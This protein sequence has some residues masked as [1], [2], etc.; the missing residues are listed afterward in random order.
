[1]KIPMIQAIE[2]MN[3][4][5]KFT[6]VITNSPDDRKIKG[7]ANRKLCL[8]LIKAGELCLKV[9]MKIVDVS[10]TT[11]MIILKEFNEAGLIEFFS[12]TG[13]KSK[14]VNVL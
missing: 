11:I 9:L 7:A 10:R 1:M 5:P 12:T 6:E 4:T 14:I 2:A 8:E 13:K 3:K